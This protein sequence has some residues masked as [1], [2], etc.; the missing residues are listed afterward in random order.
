MTLMTL[1]TLKI[2]DLIE[3]LGSQSGSL[4]DTTTTCFLCKNFKLQCKLQLIYNQEFELQLI[5]SLPFY[6]M[7]TIAQ[8][9]IPA[10]HSPT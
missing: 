9:W 3:D 7:I 5:F 6:K 2:S 10:I 4:I 1:I 8:S